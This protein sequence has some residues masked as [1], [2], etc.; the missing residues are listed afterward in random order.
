MKKMMRNILA[1][2]ALVGFIGFAAISTEA[3]NV[4]R[5]IKVH[6]GDQDFTLVNSTGV[7]INALYITPHNSK[8]WGEDILG[9]DTLLN[10]KETL[11]TFPSK[12]TA[13]IWDL[14]IED[15]DGG[16]LEWDNLNLLKISS[17]ELLYG[18]GN[19]TAILN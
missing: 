13:K 12:T 1:I 10:G 6:F 14:R 4:N 17:V 18:N 9:V 19:T 15:E 2:L 16:Y 11:I 5:N 3:K 7:E 8:D